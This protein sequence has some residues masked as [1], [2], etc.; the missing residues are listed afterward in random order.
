MLAPLQ[1]ALMAIQ[2]RASWAGQAT[3]PWP[4]QWARRP[5]G[6]GDLCRAGAWNLPVCFEMAIIAPLSLL[7]H[8]ECSWQKKPR[9]LTG[10]ELDW[11]SF[12]LIVRLPARELM[13]QLGQGCW[14]PPWSEVPC[15]SDDISKGRQPIL[16]RWAKSRCVVADVEDYVGRL[17][18]WGTCSTSSSASCWG[19][20]ASSSMARPSWPGAPAPQPASPTP[21]EKD[22][23]TARANIV[24]WLD[25]RVGRVVDTGGQKNGPSGCLGDDPAFSSAAAAG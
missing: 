14:P 12:P 13:R 9:L 2:P 22:W 21:V 1:F 20:S 4:T 25:R 6:P 7:D 5:V 3:M 10:T 8:H 16:E 11:E 24:A 23:L 17:R 19:W 18:A 15:H